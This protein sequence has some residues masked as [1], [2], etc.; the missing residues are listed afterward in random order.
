[1]KDPTPL[2]PSTTNF[3]HE[4]KAKDIA[5]CRYDGTNNLL[6]ADDSLFYCLYDTLGNKKKIQYLWIPYFS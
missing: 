1:M 5:F 6:S 2:Y 3:L 4:T